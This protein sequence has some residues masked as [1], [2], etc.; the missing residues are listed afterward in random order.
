MFRPEP[1]FSP[2]SEMAERERLLILVAEDE[3]VTASIVKA[4]LERADFDVAEAADG[5][6]AWRAYLEIRPD[7]LVADIRMPIL[8][9]AQLVRRVLSH[10]AHMPIVVFSASSEQALTI[11]HEHPQA[12]IRFVGKPWTRDE[13]VGAI[14]SLLQQS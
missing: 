5:E 14:R 1:N 3:P 7:V 11:L 13:L 4:Q 2:E 6:A 8:D 9:G 12:K 10:A